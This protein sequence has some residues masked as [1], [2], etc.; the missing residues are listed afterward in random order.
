MLDY[1]LTTPKRKLNESMAILQ[2]NEVATFL[3]DGV[4]GKLNSLA[5][6]SPYNIKSKICLL[7]I[8][9]WFYLLTLFICRQSIFAW[10]E[11]NSPSY[12]FLFVFFLLC[13]DFFF[14]FRSEWKG[15][16][17]SCLLPVKYKMALFVCTKTEEGIYS[18]N[19]IR[20]QPWQRSLYELRSTTARAVEH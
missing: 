19:K 9:S 1:L 7:K 11:R 2:C 13:M 18:M 20:C 16:L 4:V 12:F 14:G 6:K 10:S 8:V 17:Y 15:Q 5:K 3:Y